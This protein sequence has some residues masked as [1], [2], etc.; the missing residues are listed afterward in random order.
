MEELGMKQAVQQELLEFPIQAQAI[1]VG[2][3]KVVVLTKNLLLES[4]LEDR[5]R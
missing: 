1:I 5:A 2:E 4:S 3:S